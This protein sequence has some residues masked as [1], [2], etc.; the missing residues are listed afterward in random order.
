MQQDSSSDHSCFMT[1]NQGIAILPFLKIFEYKCKIVS[2]RYSWQLKPNRENMFLLLCPNCN[3]SL[4]AIMF[5]LSFCQILFT[6]TQNLGRIGSCR[7]LKYYRSIQ[8]ELVGQQEVQ[9][10]VQLPRR[11]QEQQCQV[12]V[13]SKS[14][15]LLSS[16]LHQEL[17]QRK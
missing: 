12:L 5:L 9:L 2:S 11:L 10:Q 6:Y 13:A 1:R 4:K 8:L 17:S 15:L 14:F 3:L 7:G 16:K